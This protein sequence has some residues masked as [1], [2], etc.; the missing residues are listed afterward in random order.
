MYV[1]M[2]KTKKK[3]PYFMPSENQKILS[4]VVFCLVPTAQKA[5]RRTIQPQQSMA[6]KFD[7]PIMATTN[8]T[9]PIWH[10]R[11]TIHIAKVE[12]I[13]DPGT[14]RARCDITLIRQFFV[15]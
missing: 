2:K 6:P 12:D 3:D 11:N 5:C 13:H 1:H 9:H 15:I 10:E 8:Q 7:R 14:S 4:N